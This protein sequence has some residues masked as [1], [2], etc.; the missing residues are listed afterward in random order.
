VLNITD[1]HTF[2]RQEL[3]SLAE[4]RYMPRGYS[5]EANRTVDLKMADI[6]RYLTA[7]LEATPNRLMPQRPR[8]R[9]DSLLGAAARERTLKGMVLKFVELLQAEP[10]VDQMDAYA[11]AELNQQSFE[12]G[13][14]GM[15]LDSLI[16][17]AEKWRAM[18]G[19]DSLDT[20]AVMLELALLKEQ[21]KARI[22]ELENARTGAT[23]QLANG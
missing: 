20:S 14:L 17:S 5:R 2:A 23:Q 18:A 15:E 19:A 21:V 12:A 7:A 1:L 3:R 9:Q 6:H 8:Q 11:V 10:A 13:R 4:A 16:E 22:S